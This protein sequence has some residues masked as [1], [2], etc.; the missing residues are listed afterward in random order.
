MPS[1]VQVMSVSTQGADLVDILT[2]HNQTDRGEVSYKLAH[3]VPVTTKSF[4]F[5]QNFHNEKES[6]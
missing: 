4:T 6:T 1:F 3:S 5:F 2:K